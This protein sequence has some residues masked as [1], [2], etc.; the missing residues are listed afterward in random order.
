MNT[1]V[2][3]AFNLGW[4]LA[5]AC[6][7][8][9]GPALLDSYEAERRPVALRI[10]ESGDA[11]EGNQTMTTHDERA[12]RD[13]VIRQTLAEAGSAHHEA[14]ATAEL[15]RSYADSALV[16]GNAN[17]HL[18]PGQLLPNTVRVRNGSGDLCFLHEL[19]HRVGHTV[20]VVGGKAASCEEVL[21][22]T[23]RT[24]AAVA[25]S[26]VIDAVVGLCAQPRDVRIGWIDASTA[27]ALGI[28]RVAVLA[29]RPDRYVGFR[30]DGAD[31][32]PLLDYV[33]AF[34]H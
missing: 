16:R 15:D 10:V 29:V 9:D 28:N 12:H 1:G 18:S 31:V 23:L 14:A 25:A 6:Q 7:G 34:A 17:V 24:E 3:D 27:D 8:L 22:T 21:E 13:V 33:E 4:K 20:L 32:G 26:P 30:H 5:L 2:Q 19:T 11:F